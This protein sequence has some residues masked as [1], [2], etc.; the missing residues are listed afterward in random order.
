MVRTGVANVGRDHRAAA[1][2]SFV[3]ALLFVISALLFIEGFVVFQTHLDRDTGGGERG[4]ML[5]NQRYDTAWPLLNGL[6]SFERPCHSLMALPRFDD[7][8]TLA[9]LFDF[10]GTK[11]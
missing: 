1:N 7:S 3:G 8:V 4:A 2:C 9:P 5:G 11:I 6:A 10:A